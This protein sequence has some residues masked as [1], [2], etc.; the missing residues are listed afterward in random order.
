MKLKVIKEHIAELTELEKAIN[1][2]CP[3]QYLPPYFILK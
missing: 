2:G 1:N 3:H